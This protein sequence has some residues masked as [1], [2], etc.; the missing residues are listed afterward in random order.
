MSERDKPQTHEEK[1]FSQDL[2]YG[3]REAEDA[4]QVT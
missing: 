3:L 4:T 2:V 1:H